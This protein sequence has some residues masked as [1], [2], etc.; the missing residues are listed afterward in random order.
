VVGWVRPVVAP[1]DFASMGEKGGGERLWERECVCVGARRLRVSER[2]RETESARE[3]GLKPLCHFLPLVDK[4]I[5]HKNN[6]L[7][8]LTGFLEGVV[9]R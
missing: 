1:A 3:E 6:R 8:D 2:T 5:K 4:L 7:T 9:N